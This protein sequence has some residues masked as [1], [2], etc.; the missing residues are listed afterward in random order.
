MGA[1]VDRSFS[2]LRFPDYLGTNE[3]PAYVRFEPFEMDF[4]KIQNATNPKDAANGRVDDVQTRLEKNVFGK[5]SDFSGIK[6][7]TKSKFLSGTIK[8]GG[9]EIDLDK[10][11][12]TLQP[13]GSINLFLP[14]GLSA[15]LSAQYDQVSGT[16]FAADAGKQ[17]DAA[18]GG[19][20]GSLL[21]GAVSSFSGI[22]QDVVKQLAKIPGAN[23]ITGVGAGVVANNVSFQLFKGVQNRTFQYQW[24]L[25]A[26]NPKEN[27]EI[28][29]ICDTMLYYSLPARGTSDFTDKGLFHFYEI[30][31]MWKI[32]YYY[33]DSIIPYHLQPN[34]YC[35][36]SNIDVQYP[37]QQVYSD[38]APLQ[39][40]LTLSFTEI[41]PMYRDNEKPG[42]NQDS[43]FKP[44]DWTDANGNFMGP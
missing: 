38:G 33:K 32:G 7:K 13:R 6:E 41:Q 29:K 40:G 14:E 1:Q 31:A 4:G 22:A 37:N 21:D 11:K 18:L 10:E 2:S 42:N 44:N 9:F 36:L 35:V 17:L 39:V 16:G 28:K 3:A 15:N 43:S 34:T 8:I 12:D 19:T 24:N 30:P 25:I 20:S 5:N 27:I 23:V 26:K